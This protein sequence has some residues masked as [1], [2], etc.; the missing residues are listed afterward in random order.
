MSRKNKGKRN[1]DNLVA[2]YLAANPGTSVQSL[3]STALQQSLQTEQDADPSGQNKGQRYALTSVDMQR[4]RRDTI[5]YNNSANFSG[6]GRVKIPSYVPDFLDA[7]VPQSVA[8][9]KPAMHR[10]SPARTMHMMSAR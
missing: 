7:P 6:S 5:L 3:F 9:P 2:R 10:P 4:V 8:S 1:D